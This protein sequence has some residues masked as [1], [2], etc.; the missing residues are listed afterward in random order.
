MK[1]KI[2]THIRYIY[3][4]MKVRDI[5][6]VLVSIHNIMGC[7]SFKRLYKRMTQTAEGLEILRRRPRVTREAIDLD[8]L[9]TLPKNT[10]GFLFAEHMLAHGFEKGIESPPKSPFE[11]ENTA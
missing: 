6:L 4:I 3:H 10:F 1:N 11:N 5:T 9:L 7:F 8:M 2:I